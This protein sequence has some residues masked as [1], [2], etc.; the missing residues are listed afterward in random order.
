[1]LLLRF[2]NE[3]KNLPCWEVVQLIKGLGERAWDRG[4][5]PVHYVSPL[6]CPVDARES[7][8]P[9]TISGHFT[10]PTDESYSS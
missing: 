2:D 8:C 7:E 9:I 10:A 5:L 3:A 4:G 1:M 6:L